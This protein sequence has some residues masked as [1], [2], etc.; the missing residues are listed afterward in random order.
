MI[1][2]YQC[3]KHGRR[4]T[5]EL[6]K[7]PNRAGPRSLLF[8]ELLVFYMIYRAVFFFYM[9][10]VVVV[11]LYLSEKL[12]RNDRGSVRLHCSVP[13]W[14][15]AVPSWCLRHTTGHTGWVPRER[16]RPPLRLPLPLV[17]ARE[18]V[19]PTQRRKE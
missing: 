15:V 13:N 10:V 12:K 11:H 14:T 4:H 6:S 3:Y 7:W 8:S 1:V 2:N 17:R 16:S 19:G 9:V 5:I 18:R